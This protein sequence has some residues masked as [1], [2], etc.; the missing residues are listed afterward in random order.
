MPDRMRRHSSLKSLPEGLV[1]LRDTVAYRESLK[2]MSSSDLLLVIDGPDEISVFLPSKLIDYLGAR[3]PIVGIVPPGTSAKL[4]ARLG[5]PVADPRNP[6]QIASSLHLALKLASD[7]RHAVNWQPWG[8]P[9]IAS[10][11]KVENVAA[12]FGQ[13]LEVTLQQKRTLIR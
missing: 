9:A 11:Y 8:D 7:R 2:L 13:M 4:L 6:E 1:R 5:A 3:V 12:A 10:E